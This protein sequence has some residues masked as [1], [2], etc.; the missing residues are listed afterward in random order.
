MN[1]NIE[2]ACFAIFDSC[3]I[4]NLSVGKITSEGM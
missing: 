1:Y 4:G 2:F 3:D